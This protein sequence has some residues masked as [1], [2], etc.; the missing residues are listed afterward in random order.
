MQEALDP[1]NL[2]IRLP[3]VLLALTVHEYCHAWFAL[4]MGDATARDQ[5]RLSL[6]P[7]RHLDPLGT[8]CLIFAPI[9]WA[10]AVPIN[11]LNFRNRRAGILVSTIAGPAS[12]LV[13]A[14]VYALVLRLM[15]GW[16]AGSDAQASP[17]EARVAGVL[18]LACLFGVTV[19]VGLAVFNLLPLFPLDGFHV[20]S[21]LLGEEGRRRMRDMA[22]Y[23][24]LAI[25]GLVM[26]GHLG[27]VD[28]LG[29]LIRPVVRL[30]FRLVAGVEM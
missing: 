14:V 21:Q 8:V 9:G 27:S 25:L 4:R 17:A 11:P 15:L 19:N 16:L 6:N 30:V 5:G 3:V 28:V 20:L 2:A 13:Q 24:P 12:N 29:G 18:A 22:A 10:R 26:L 7:L 1:V 23:G